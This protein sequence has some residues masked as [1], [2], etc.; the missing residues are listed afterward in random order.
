[1]TTRCQPSQRRPAL[2]LVMVAAIAAVCL[3]DAKETE[4][5]TVSNTVSTDGTLP[6]IVDLAPFYSKVFAGPEDPNSN[7]KGYFGRKIV[8]GLPFDVN[9]ECLLYGKSNAE[10]GKVCRNEVSGIKIGR[11][12]DE[13]HLIHAVQ[14]RE[15]YGCPVAS[16]RLHYADGAS[17]DFEIRYNFQVNDWARLLSEEREIIDDPD[18]K[19]IWRGPGVYKGTGRLF[20]TVLHNRFPDKKVDSMDIISTRTRASYVLVAATVADGDPHREVTAPMPLEPGGNFDGVLKVR[21]VDKETGAPMAGAEVYPSMIVDDEGVVADPILASTNGVALVKYPVSRTSSVWVEVSKAGYL[22][23]NGYWQSGSI[24]DEITYRLTVSRATIQGAVLNEAGQPVAGAEVRFNSYNFDNT[25][26]DQVNLPSESATTDAAGH[27][28]FQ[29][30][31]ENYQNFGVTVT[32][33][34][35][36]QARFFADGPGRRGM[37]GNHISTADFYSGRASLKLSSGG[38]LSGRVHD[39]A[40]HP[41]ANAAV[42]AGFER[43]MMGAIKTN[44]DAGGNFNLKTGL[45]QNYL[46]ISARG[47]APEF[48]TVT[49]A[50]GDAPQEVVLKPGNVIHGRVLDA[51]GKPIEGAQVSYD[52]LADRRGIFNGRTIEWKMQTD[53]NGEFTWDSAPPKRILLSITKSGYMSLNW[54]PVQTDTTNI[55]IFTLGSPLTIKGSVTDADTGGPVARFKVTPGWPQGDGGIRFEKMRAGSG[56]SGRYEVH[57]DSPIVISPTPYDFVFQISASGYAPAQSRAIKANEGVVTWDVKLKKTPATIAQIKKADGKPAADAKVLLVARRDFVQLDGTELLNQNQN[58][59]SFQTDADGHFELPPQ[60][61]DFSLAAAS[62]SGFAMVS[63]AEFMNSLTLTLQPWGRIEGDLL[64]HG[65]PM[66]GRELYFFVGDGSDQ[67]N[68]SGKNP[69]TVDA[70]GHFIF[71]QVPAGTIRIELKQPMTER[72][73]SYLELQTL[74][75]MPGG[76]NTIQIA[77]NGRDVIG[78]WKRNADLPADVDLEQGNIFLRPDPGPLPGLDGLN[79]VEKIQKWYQDLSK[80]NSSKKYVAAARKGGQLQMKPDGTLRGEAIAPGKYNLSANFWGGGS[81]VAE[82]ESREVVVPEI[83]TND[84]DAPF[85]LGEIVVKA[86]KHL[87]IGDAAPAFS[88]KTLDGRPLKLSD[89]H[90]KY[91]LLDFWATWCGPCVAETP[92]LKAAY[93][94]YGSDSRFV[95]VSLSLDQTAGLPEKFA[96]DHDIKWQQGFLGEWSKDNVTKDYSVRG[97]PSIFLLGPDGTIIAQNLRGEEIKRAVGAALAAK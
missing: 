81:A 97:I 26:E 15:Y 43:F 13:L 77:Q 63:Q 56:S 6:F 24:P 17:S 87:N 68:L 69:V 37:Q 78:H 5:A 72:S 91:V 53:P 22:G 42:F 85:D 92:H 35:F 48:R 40:G 10:R 39:E 51:A 89:L 41:L 7:F 14:W 73:W 67:R 45:G 65:R 25:A 2:A 16:I 28:S 12:F 29:G 64:N 9:G 38:K 31:P 49:V 61:G 19:I 8:D 83:S 95:M 80:T 21:V 4:N 93:D 3:T 1:M 82:V 79:I 70:R 71:P 86:V 96:R 94:A 52:G 74:E 55:T 27:W 34:D 88:V 90:G 32:H 36:P 76:T 30:V 62:P 54:F 60:T 11:K 50:A 20:E 47:F 59:D 18:T 66:P 44:T 75:V 58:G 84:P 57:F 23:R 33:P 46:T